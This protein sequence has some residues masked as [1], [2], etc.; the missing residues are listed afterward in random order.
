MNRQ[1][2]LRPPKR[3]AACLF[4]AGLPEFDGYSVMVSRAVMNLRLLT[5][6]FLPYTD[7][8]FATW[9]T[10]RSGD[11]GDL[12][13]SQSIDH[14]QIPFGLW[15]LAPISTLARSS[16]RGAMVSSAASA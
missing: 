5:A 16:V 15:D 4:A 8:K 10:Y 6:K 1:A 7:I 9:F 2:P 13:F 14:I 12:D 11:I 3:R